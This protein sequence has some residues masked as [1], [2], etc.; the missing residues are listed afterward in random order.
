MTRTEFEVFK[1]ENLLELLRCRK[2]L[3]H[4]KRIQVSIPL[5]PL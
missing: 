5:Y 1:N 4:K 3:S 2:N